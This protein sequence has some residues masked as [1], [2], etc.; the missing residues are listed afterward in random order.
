[1]FDYIVEARW[2]KDQPSAA[3][4]NGFE[5]K[6][7]RKLESTRG[8]FVAVQGVRPEV[9]DT[10]SGRGCNI[11]FVDGYD[12]TQILEGRVDFRGTH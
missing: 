11:V 7:E 1:M 10:F 3:E 12:L 6:V 5:G 2:L 4:I 8:L 9:V